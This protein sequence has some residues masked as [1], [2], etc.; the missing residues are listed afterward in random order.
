[1][2]LAELMA[3]EKPDRVQIEKKM[4]EMNEASFAAQKSGMEHHL[5]M[6]E[7]LTP[8]QKANM[9][10]WLQEQRQQRMERGFGPRRG[11]DPRGPRP[12]MEP[13]ARPPAN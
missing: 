4:R 9:Q 10:Q 6:R 2:E 12:P 11:P 8:E 13:Q 7:M 3:A 1:M 5:A